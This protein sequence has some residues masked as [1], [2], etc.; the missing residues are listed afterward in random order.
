MKYRRKWSRMWKILSLGLSILWRVYWYQL[1]KR[2]DSEMEKLWGEIGEEFR[3]TL[4]DL[5]GLLIKVGQFLSIR[6]DLLPNSFVKQLEDLVDHVP[7]SM[8]DDIRQVLEQ[9]WEDKIEDK[10][11]SIR[12]TAIASASIGE[13]YKGYLKDG[14]CVAIKVQRP[15]IGSII[16]TDF[17]A[18]A[19]IIWIAHHFAPVP[20]QFINFKLL[21][22]EL[23]QVIKRE[24]DFHQE[25]E[26][27][28]HFRTHFQKMDKLIIP[29]VYPE[30]ST[31]R[32]LVMEWVEGSKITDV[33]FLEKYQVNT[34][35]LSIRLLQLFIP[36][37]LEA[38]I[39]HADPHAGNV[40]VKPD[41]TIILLDFGMVGEISKKDADSFQDLLQAILLKNYSMAVQVLTEL[42]FIYPGA[43]TT[44]IERILKEALSID[45]AHYKE[46]DLFAVKK[47]LND[48]VRSLPIQVPTRFIFLGRSFVTIEGMLHTISPKSELL[49]IAKPA[50]LKWI[51]QTNQSK[52][53]L[54]WKWI[55]AQPAFRVFHSIR[56]FLEAPKRFIEWKEMQQERDFYFTSTENQKK[57]FF[58][59]GLLGITGSIF[60]VYTKIVLITDVGIGITGLSL[61]AY[62]ICTKKQRKWLKTW[63]K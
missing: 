36:Q 4:F 52:W 58:F 48:L 21:F 29:K 31:S 43:D 27:I 38:G 18:L 8:W 57:H 47:E 24:L 63:R 30:L 46:M 6:S 22:H 33:E 2:P 15:K 56:D 45:L 11:E 10:L 60:G 51:R 20:K 12:S 44:K 9:E 19:I 3:Q 5:E 41:G 59:L 14:T 40:L 28:Q 53:K 16:Q 7:P 17:R 37:W 34:E 54:I 25:M 35:D 1:R 39:F 42:G 26:A 13:V 32:V 23:Q 55:Y 62:I 61:I 49:D 50:F